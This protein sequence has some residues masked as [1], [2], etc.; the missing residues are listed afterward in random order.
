MWKVCK[1]KHI[2]Q[3]EVH[4]LQR[5]LLVSCTGFIC[6]Y[7]QSDFKKNNSALIIKAISGKNE[8]IHLQ[9][10]FCFGCSYFFNFLWFIYIYII[11]LFSFAKCKTKEIIFIILYIFLVF[12]L[13]LQH[14]NKNGKTLK[15]KFIRCAFL[16]IQH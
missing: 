15:I 4:K 2:M 9:L 12:V 8:N 13:F 16:Y 3:K 7:C 10:Y 14:T 6:D 1:R 5:K 11:F